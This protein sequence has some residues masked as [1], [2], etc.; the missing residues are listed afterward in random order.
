MNVS[1]SDYHMFSVMKE[2]LGIRNFKNDRQVETVVT[3]QLV[4][5]V[6]DTHQ[7]GI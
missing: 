4:A 3:Q 7:Q 6:K 5:Q 1:Q 2:N